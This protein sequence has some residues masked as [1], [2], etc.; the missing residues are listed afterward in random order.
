MGHGS[1]LH[2]L[3]RGIYLRLENWIRLRFGTSSLHELHYGHHCMGSARFLRPGTSR[4]L[5]CEYGD[6]LRRVEL[7]ERGIPPLPSPPLRPSLD[8]DARPHGAD[9]RKDER[10]RLT[11]LPRF[12][13]NAAF[14]RIDCSAQNGC[15]CRKTYPLG[16]YESRTEVGIAREQN[17]TCETSCGLSPEGRRPGRAPCWVST[18]PQPP[19]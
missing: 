13:C 9:S 7:H 8:R 10:V 5:F 17:Q 19:K 18:T 3:R 4:R 2:F 6:T 16:T 11:G 14:H 1:F 15:A 12:G